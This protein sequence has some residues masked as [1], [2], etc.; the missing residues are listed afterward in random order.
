MLDK[1][2]ISKAS[3]AYAKATWNHDEHQY[4]CMDG[5]NA[6]ANWAIKEFLKDLWHDAMEEP[7]KGKYII[8]KI[9]DEDG[10]AYEVGV[11]YPYKTTDWV[12]HVKHYDILSWCYLDD[13][14][15]QKGG[16]DV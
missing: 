13:I 10:E 12:N 5:F 11:F 16:S 4:F 6:G 7:K 2:E 1:N 8:E 15:P 9:L 3:A 14:L